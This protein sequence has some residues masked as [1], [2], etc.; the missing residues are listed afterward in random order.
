M[1]EFTFGGDAWWLLDASYQRSWGKIGITWVM[2]MK[3]QG[4]Q[5]QRFQIY[6]TTVWKESTM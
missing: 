6:I 3:K 2:S 5:G 4:F 1:V